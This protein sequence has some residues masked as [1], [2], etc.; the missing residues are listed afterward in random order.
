MAAM[1]REERPEQASLFTVRLWSHREG[2]LAEQR[3]TVRSV[4]TGAYRSFR[5]WDELVAFLVDQA[6]RA[7]PTLHRDEPTGTGEDHG[8]L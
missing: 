1:E 5:H 6:S 8:P 4:E 3:G 2:G 7:A